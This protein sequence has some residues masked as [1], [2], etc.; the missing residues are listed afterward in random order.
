MAEQSTAPWTLTSDPS[1]VAACRGRARIGVTAGLWDDP[2]LAALV[3]PPVT[4]SAWV[5]APPIPQGRHRALDAFPLTAFT[6]GPI[7]VAPSALSG[8]AADA[9]PWTQPGAAE[10][11]LP[12][13]RDLAGALA[14]A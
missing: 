8:P 11:E 5:A 12:T 13:W 10:A 7:A 3:A 14:P 2:E 6:P 9:R 4:V 1:D